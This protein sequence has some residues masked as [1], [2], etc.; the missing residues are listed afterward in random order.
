MKL[1]FIPFTGKKYVH[2]M[3]LSYIP[4]KNLES[5]LYGNSSTFKVCIRKFK[6][7]TR[8]LE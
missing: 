6:S 4:Q 5:P 7:L 1:V 3:D 8:N 2:K